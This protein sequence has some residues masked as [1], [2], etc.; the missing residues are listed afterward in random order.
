MLALANVES[1]AAITF[2]KLAALHNRHVS[3]K[4]ELKD[5]SEGQEFSFECV[6]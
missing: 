2:S 6:V 4:N 3:I 1:A 5:C